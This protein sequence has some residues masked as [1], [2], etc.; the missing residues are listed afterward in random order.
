MRQR[1][2][3]TV[4]DVQGYETILDQYSLSDEIDDGQCNQVSIGVSKLTGTPVAIKEIRTKKYLKLAAENSIC[5]AEAITLCKGSK[6]VV[7]LLN[8]FELENF[9]YIITKFEEGRNLLDYC[10]SQPNQTQWMSEQ[11]VRFIF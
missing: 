9:T 11:R 10:L 7:K 6:R 5:E 4:L 2:L 1:V 8:T 3:R